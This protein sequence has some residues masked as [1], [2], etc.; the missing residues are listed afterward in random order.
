MGIVN[1]TPDSFSDGGRFFDTQT[2]I[3]HAIQLGHDGADILDIG[4]ESTRPGSDPVDAEEE[5][6]R[7]VPVVAALREYFSQQF[8]IQ[9]NGGPIISVDT[10]KAVVAKAVLDAGA[11]IINDVS[12][13]A[14][15]DMLHVLQN[16][17]AKICVMHAQGT[18]KTM[19][20]QPQYPNDDPVPV[21]LE[22]LR[23]RVDFLVN[24]GVSRDRIIV[25]PGIGFGKT[26]EHNMRLIR[27]MEKFHELGCP[28][29]VGHSRKR[30]LAGI[31]D[32]RN[33]ATLTV[34]RQ[35]ARQGVA[36]LRVH[37]VKEHVKMFFDVDTNPQN[38]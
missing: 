16:S 10:T 34:S 26:L 20:I 15:P 21:V 6:R 17:V 33:A 13:L 36:I 5:L 28:I 37:D 38:R 8:S 19:Q 4:G 31:S 11:D 2:A 30:F 18:P 24:S 1:V 32:D 25:D 23:E 22:F 27:D 9:K 35:L 7:V 29:L 12:S 3:E 14:D